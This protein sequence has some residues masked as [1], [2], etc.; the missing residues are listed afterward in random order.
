MKRMFTSVR[1]RKM[2]RGVKSE[3]A[4]AGVAGSE[5]LGNRRTTDECDELEP[6]YSSWGDMVAGRAARPE[7][8]D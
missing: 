8:G 1:R 3:T 5:G 4:A 6:L 2:K 7:V